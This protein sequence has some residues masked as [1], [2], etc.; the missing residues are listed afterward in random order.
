MKL[1]AKLTLITTAVTA[2]AALIGT[3]FAIGFAKQNTEDQIISA[4]I[5][6]FCLFY[7]DFSDTAFRA[8][9]ETVE[10]QNILRYQFYQTSGFDEYILEQGDSIISNN[11][12]IDAAGVLDK[13]GYATQTAGRFEEPLRYTICK[14]GGRD[15]LMISAEINI[16]ERELSLSLARD[17]TQTM[18]AVRE[19]ALKCAAAGAGVVLMAAAV[20]WLLSRRSLKPIGTLEAGASE[21]AAGSYERRIP[22][23]GHDEIAMLAEKFND[24]AEAISEKV[25]ELSDTAERQK[26][27]INGLSHELKTPVTSILARSE[28][29]LVRDLSEEDKRRSLERIYDQSAWLERLAGKLMTLTMLD[30]TIEMRPSSVPE[31]LDSVETTMAG[32]LREYGVRLEI[33]CTMD[34]LSMDADLMRSA[35]VN[36][37]ENAKRAS[38]SGSCVGLSAQDGVITVRDHG[39]GI[40]PEEISRVTEPFYMVDRSRSKKSGGSGLGLALVK[41]IA[42]AH[43]ARLEIASELGVGTSVSLR[44]SD[45]DKKITSC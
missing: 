5:D 11:T 32:A 24:M 34:V 6:D 45:D 31:L 43:H 25:S 17:I 19:L 13:K 12:G 1:G 3:V 23:K 44:F 41:R 40:P 35:L 39:K 7:N 33:D 2:S 16:L 22:V 37:I 14:V 9:P 10:G 20:V 38:P 26:I 30:G 27:F 15:Y 28:T 21:I 36:L 8:D 4:G 42:E 18:S 29:L